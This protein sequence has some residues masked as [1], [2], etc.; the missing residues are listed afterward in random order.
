MTLLA[1]MA[2]AGMSVPN[3]SLP[4]GDDPVKGIEQVRVEVPSAFLLVWVGMVL[5]SST[6]GVYRHGKRRCSRRYACDRGEI[7]DPGHLTEISRR[8]SY[9]IDDSLGRFRPTFSQQVSGF[10]PPYQGSMF[11]VQHADEV[12]G[13]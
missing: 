12:G 6:P 4:G 10:E 7:V 5:S 1:T 2:P 9:R 13:N 8:G 11:R 3:V